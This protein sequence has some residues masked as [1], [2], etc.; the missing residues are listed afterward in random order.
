M[1]TRREYSLD[2]SNLDQ[3]APPT[4]GTGVRLRPALP[5]DA[6]ALAELMIDAYR[7]TI[8]YD[9]ETLE[10]ALAEIQAYLAGQRGGQP[11]LADSRLAFAGPNLVAACLA[12]DWQERRRPVVAYVMT[13]AGW[14]NRGL[15][16]QVLSA[17]L[18]S[19]R[20]QGHHQVRA[21]ITPGNTPSERLF[22]RLGFRR[23]G[24]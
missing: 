3:P 24:L 2:L 9:G 19:L 18:H 5:A 12:C 20:E 13:R 23:V 14:K 7:G 11:L 6:G 21:V 17:V 15:G 22:C 1:G 16:R 4:A 10:D 8:D